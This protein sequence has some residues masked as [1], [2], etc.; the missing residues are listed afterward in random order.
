[1]KSRHASSADYGSSD[2]DSDYDIESNSHNNNSNNMGMSYFDITAST[3]EQQA[4]A[5]AA[6]AAMLDFEQ[7]EDEIVAEHQHA[8]AHAHLREHQHQHQPQQQLHLLIEEEVEEE[9]SGESDHFLDSLDYVHTRFI[10]NVPQEKLSTS[11]RIIFQLEQAWWYYEDLICDKLEQDTGHCNL[12]RF[13][14]L[15]PFS[16]RLFE[17]S[18]LLRNNLQDFDKLWNEFSIYKR[19][20]STYG[21]YNNIV[22]IYIYISF[23]NISFNHVMYGAVQQDNIFIFWFLQVAC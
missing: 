19:K 4:A 12:P 13:A 6:V 5:A 8:H 2:D 9:Q 7:V 15:K 11:D 21:W 10:L 17:F 1:M 20:I 14:N 3:P 22:T 18:P 23:I 16:K